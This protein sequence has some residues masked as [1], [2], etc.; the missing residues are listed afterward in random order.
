MT[1]N[2]MIKNVADNVDEQ[3]WTD[4]FEKRSTEGFEAALASDRVLNASA[5]VKPIVGRDLVKICMGTASTVVMLA[6]IACSGLA[7]ANAASRVQY[8]TYA[9]RTGSYWRYY[10]YPRPNCTIPIGEFQRFWSG[11]LW[12]PSMRCR[13]Y[14]H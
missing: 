14:P 6:L 10:G 5:L 11:Q 12:P 3:S 7:E 4:A 1:K 13:P 9:E 8:R 2:T